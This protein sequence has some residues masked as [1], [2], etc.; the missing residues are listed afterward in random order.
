MPGPK[1][2]DR[3]ETS[4]S[5]ALQLPVCATAGVALRLSAGVLVVDLEG[6]EA[7]AARRCRH[8]GRAR[9]EK[10][11]APISPKLTVRCCS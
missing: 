11:D 8:C 4:V 1:P 3:F 5:R 9:D 10:D 6:D 7:A 2:M